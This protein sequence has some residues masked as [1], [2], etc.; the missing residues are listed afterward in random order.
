MQQSG[1]PWGKRSAAFRREV[2]LQESWKRADRTAKTTE[3]VRREQQ[4]IEQFEREDEA[5]VRVQR[6]WRRRQRRRRDVRA[7]DVMVK[8][9]VRA[10]PLMCPSALSRISARLPCVART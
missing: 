6:W 7:I 2:L 3:H 9:Q 1:W 5:A 4:L 8:V 10:Q